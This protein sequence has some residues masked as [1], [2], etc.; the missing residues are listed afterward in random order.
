MLAHQLFD[1]AVGGHSGRALQPRGDDRPG[2]AG[3]LHDPFEG[4]A[5]QQPMTERATKSVTSAKTVDHLDRKRLN[6]DSRVA[7]SGQHA[8]RTL[9]D[10]SELQPLVHQRLRRTVR[11]ALAHRHL[12]LLT[13]SDSNGH[14][15]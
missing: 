6:L 4:P 9:L 13:I 12:T 1:L 3:K 7:R 14:H 8:S 2:N 10:D 5:R 15:R 11:I